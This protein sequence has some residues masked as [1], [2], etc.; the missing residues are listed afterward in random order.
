MD[1]FLNYFA[2][3]PTW[4]KAA[5]LFACLCGGWLLEASFPF[6]RY[7]YNRVKHNSVNLV[8]LGFTLLINTVFSLATVKLIYPLIET[9][10]FG[11]LYLI[12][13]PVWAELAIAILLFDLVAQ[14]TVHLML[15]KVTWM[16]R[17]HMIHHS[18]TKV[19]ATSGTRHHP[20]DYI[21]RE[22]FSLLTILVTGAPFAYYMLYRIITI[23]FTYLT[24]ANIL[25]PR[26]LDKPLSFIFI[27]PNIH[28]FHHH[29]QLPWTDSNYGNIFSFWDRLFKTLVYDDPQKIKYGLDIL[30]GTDDESI[31]FQL[32]I[33]FNKSIPSSVVEK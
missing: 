32:N 19:V 14:Y 27:T 4:Q 6:F 18:D 21:T 28:K 8:F 5:W 22:L 33:P 20:G 2:T 23:P 24:H 12:D 9:H 7:K 16:W 31:G 30:E 29:Y 11:L 10:R 15:H 3:L 26:W 1:F 25:V 13:L 17:L